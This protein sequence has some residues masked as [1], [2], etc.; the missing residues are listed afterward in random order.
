ME[1]KSPL[2][3]WVFSCL[4]TQTSAA[5]AAAAA[6]LGLAVDLGGLTGTQKLTRFCRDR[7]EIKYVF[8]R[9]RAQA[10]VDAGCF[11]LE[12]VFQA[13]GG[14]D[15]EEGWEEEPSPASGFKSRLKGGEQNRSSPALPWRASKNSLQRGPPS[16]FIWISVLS[17][18][19]SLLSSYEAG[20]EK[21]PW[22][23]LQSAAP[24][25]RRPTPAPLLPIRSRESISNKT[26]RI[27][28]HVGFLLTPASP[29]QTLIL[30]G[31]HFKHMK[32]CS[33]GTK[34][35]GKARGGG[36]ANGGGGKGV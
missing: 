17:F 32:G 3:N 8:G 9:Q 20:G 11:E 36:M 4:Q 16:T 19:F 35:K 24:P 29:T 33:V 6:R 13:G 28:P 30:P 15:G 1:P 22:P 27:H 7:R 23:F 18:L 34:A 14:A 2:L 26:P 10:D 31:L 21:P 5:A 12:E 25:P